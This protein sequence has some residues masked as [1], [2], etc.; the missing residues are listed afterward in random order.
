MFSNLSKAAQ[1]DFNK[2]KTV[3]LKA[4]NESE[5][6]KIVRRMHGIDVDLSVAFAMK[7]KFGLNGY[8]TPE[9]C[10]SKFYADLKKLTTCQAL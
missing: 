10:F 7:Y 5:A 8:N 2:I 9:K 1:K 4:E 3:V 6:F